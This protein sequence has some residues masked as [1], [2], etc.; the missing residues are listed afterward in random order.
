M[1]HHVSRR[2]LLATAFGG[3]GASLLTSEFPSSGAR[4]GTSPFASPLAEEKLVVACAHVGPISDNGWD[5]THHLGMQAVRKAFPKAKALEVENVPFS[6]AGT[7]VFRQLA[8]QGANVIF[9]T[10]EYADLLYEV[11]EK[12]PEIAFLQCNGAKSLENL[13]GFYVEHW[14]PSF[15]IGVAAGLLTKSNKLGYVGAFPVPAVYC[16]S[17]AF[18]LGAR[19]VNP[20]VKTQAVMINS[21]FDPQAANQAGSALINDGCDV[22]FGIMNEPAYLQV[23]EQRKAWAAMW[24]ADMRRYGPNAYLSSVMLD[25]TKFYVD[26]VA[27]RIAGKWQGKTILLPMGVGT[28]RD[29]WG[30]GVPKEIAQKADDIRSQIVAGKN[31]FAGPIKDSAGAVRIK[32]GEM[33][34]GPALFKWDWSVEG[35]SG[36]G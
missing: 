25:W 12:H 29:P 4:A 6:A 8:D 11:V 27:A 35:V 14:N 16:G 13:T 19:S 26:Q 31:Y 24:N 20:N 30:V 33:L 5:M 3:L 21:W 9:V 36:V 10:T 28:D 22:L 23:A 7:R 1:T 15:V 34:D 18:H 32:D 2:R 17:N